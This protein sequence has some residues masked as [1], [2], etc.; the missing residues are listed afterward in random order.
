M[1]LDD[2]KDADGKTQEE[3]LQNLSEFQISIIQH[4]LKCKKERKKRLMI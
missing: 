4:A 3:R 1:I 2:G